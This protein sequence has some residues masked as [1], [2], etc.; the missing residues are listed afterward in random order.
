[1]FNIT[2]DEIDFDKVVSFCELW[3]EGVRVDYKVEPANIAKVVSSFANTAG[4][5]LIVGVTTD[6]N[7]MPIFPLVG[8][9]ARPG[10]EEQIT[11]SCYQG[12][13]PPIIPLVKV[14]PLPTDPRRVLVI[15]KVHESIEAPHAIENSTR[16]YVRVNSTSGHVALADIDRIEYLFS[17]RVNAEKRRDGLIQKAFAMTAIS[18]PRLRVTIGPHYPDK[19]VLDLRR[20]QEIFQKLLDDR[21]VSLLGPHT[22]LIQNAVANTSQDS[23][24]QVNLFGQL[25]HDR[26]L[27]VGSL[28]ATGGD[29]FDLVDITLAI[30]SSMRASA[31]VLE[32]D[33]TNLLVKV[34][35][36]GIRK[37]SIIEDPADVSRLPPTAKDWMEAHTAIEETAEAE[38]FTLSET[39]F[40]EL[41]KHAVELVRQ[42]MWAFNWADDRVE[43]KVL[44]VLR[45][46]RYLA[47]A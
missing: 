4:G 11:Q 32:R 45:H 41:G 10:I 40:K 27:R 23:Y 29:H 5:I 2:F 26:R 8:Y 13:Y 9:L 42:L 15:V 34:A 46:N 35:L 44:E 3:S 6:T 25:F 18:P 16:V 30:A 20:I 1:M 19:H 17:R 14:I 37:R 33:P 38:I 36:E 22:R 28:K 7:N 24:T 39:L 21:L 31:L 43:Q 47:H 12:I